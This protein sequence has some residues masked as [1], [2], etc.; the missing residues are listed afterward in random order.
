VGYPGESAVVPMHLEGANISRAVGLLRPGRNITP[1]VL[2]CYLNS[3][4]GRRSFL[5]PSAGSAQLVVNLKDLN[6][7][8]IPVPVLD[9]QRAISEFLSDMEAEI[10]AL[11]KQREKVR[12]L[13]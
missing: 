11:E 2:V 3:P 8:Q 5:T 1:D 7:L 13:K 4:V 9:E 6:R 10:M 12:A